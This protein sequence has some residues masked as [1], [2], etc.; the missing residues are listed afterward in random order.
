M[1]AD[2]R[3]QRMLYDKSETASPT[4]STDALL[5][6]IVVDAHEQRDVAT[7]DVVGAYLKAYM[8]D[9]VV[10][11]FTGASVDIL[12]SMNQ[13]YKRFVRMENGVKVLYVRLIKAFY[14]CVKS[15][16]LWHDMF[17]GTLKEMGFEINPYNPCV[18]NCMMEGKQCTIAWYVDDNKI[19]HVNPDVVTKVIGKIKERFGKMTV[20]RGK[21]HVFLGMSIRYTDKRTA[22]VT[23]KSYL[24]E[25]IEE[26][27]LNI[28]QTGVF[29]D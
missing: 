1:V 7:A 25:A 14:D 10:M 28:H 22:V 21:E 20:T 8:K 17:H 27:G 13:K 26:S 23:M 9:F 2:G 11:K 19:S 4:V 16:L 6:S 29:L 3:P 18:A 5:L 24:N 12:C 15:A